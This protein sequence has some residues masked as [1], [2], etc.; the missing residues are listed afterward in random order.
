[1]A[2]RAPRNFSWTFAITAAA[3]SM[4][5]LDRQIVAIALPSIGADLH[6]G[7]QPLEWTVSAYTRSF[8]VL[9]LSAAGLGDRA[10]SLGA[11]AAASLPR[12]SRRARRPAELRP[13]PSID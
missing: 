9:L 7:L 1:M 12:A 11:L 4:F 8:C 5:A 10:A 3:L 13:L 2:I 6:A